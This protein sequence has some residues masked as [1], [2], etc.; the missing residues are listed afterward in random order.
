M[1]P[2]EVEVEVPESRQVT[3]T[4]PPEARPG[5]VRLRISVETGDAAP[6]TTVRR[7]SAILPDPQVTEVRSGIIQLDEPGPHE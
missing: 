3:V 7:L 5:R 1:R 2:F 6:V 4:L